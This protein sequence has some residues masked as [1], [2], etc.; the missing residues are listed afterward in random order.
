MQRKILFFITMLISSMG[1]AQTTD[2]VT[3]TR[4]RQDQKVV[5]LLSKI[6]SLLIINNI[7]LE[8][9]EINSSL[10]VRYKLYQ[11]DNIYTLLQLDTKTGK[12]DQVQW[13]LETDNEGSITINDQDLSYGAGY[14]SG[15]FELYPTKN[16]YQFILID[17]TDGRKWHVQWG[18]GKNKR[19]IRRMY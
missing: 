6:D 9:L 10:K 8:H 13:S 3:T 19:W 4:D 14:G 7:L 12:I 18:I 1:M 11:T 17:K 2:S 15:R 5:N 16:M